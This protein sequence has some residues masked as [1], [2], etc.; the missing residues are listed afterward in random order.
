MQQIHMLD[1][2]CIYKNLR[3]I[4]FPVG[5]KLYRLVMLRINNILKWRNAE[6]CSE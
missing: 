1:F 2:I 6:T 5:A 3:A 4:L